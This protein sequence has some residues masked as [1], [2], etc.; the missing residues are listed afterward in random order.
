MRCTECEEIEL[1]RVRDEPPAQTLPI[2]HQALDG[3]PA[4]RTPSHLTRRRLL[5]WGVAGAASVYGA[6]ELGWEQVWESVAAAADAEE[7]RV[8]VLLYL[9]GG[10]DGL[11]V[12]VPNFENDWQAYKTAR[13]SIYRGRG[14][15]EAGRVG[16]KPLTGPGGEYLAFSNV[17]VSTTG[18]GD[19]GD[20]NFG[21][22]TL[23]G[24]GL[25]GAGSDLAVMPA[26]DALKYNL[27][28]FD[29][30][31]IWFAASNDL[32]V[33]TGWLGRYI[34]KVGDPANPLQAISID[35]ALSKSIR[36]ASKPVCAIP[37]LASLGFT[38]GTGTYAPAG[39]VSNVQ[40]NADMQALSTIG[41]SEQN[42]YLTRSRATYGT[43]VTTWQRSQA[44]GP[45]LPPIPTYPATGSLSPKLKLA[46]HLIAANL[47]TRVITIHWGGF[48][49]HTSQLANQDRQLIELSRALGAFRADL[50]ARDVEHRVSTLVF[51]EFGRRVM[52]AGTGTDAGTDHGAGGLMMA[53][54]SAVRG[55]FASRW[56]GCKPT[57]LVPGAPPNQGNLRVTTDFRSVYSAVLSEWFGVDPMEVLG[58]PA[59]A[60]LERGDGYTGRQLFV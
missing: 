51:S 11:N 29:N 55:G 8:L 28:H 24:N 19:N 18:D 6:Q 58:G 42:A 36:T 26:V 44:A 33:K 23:F 59:I 45:Q 14:P 38:T 20:A 37:S 40:L 13:P 25:G 9:A 5:Q 12:I 50:A 47:G 32:N 53:M 52:E 39:G 41:A 60:T 49:T 4:G 30:S 57:E 27:S 10:N 34:D 3:F 31:D 21:F 35:T 16:S 46:A 17:T 1:A 43:A 2:P 48:D 15:T 22:D 54:G 7:P 56:P